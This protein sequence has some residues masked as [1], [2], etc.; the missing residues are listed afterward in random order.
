MTPVEGSEIDPDK[1]P[2]GSYAID[3][4][5]LGHDVSSSL[6]DTLLQRVPSAQINDVTGNPFQPDVQY[7]GFTASPV[8][9]TPQG[10]AVYQNG[11]RTNEAF[12]D[13]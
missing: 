5:A 10:L 7:R 11:V 12:G 8:L 3:R 1:I 6:P 4:A 13:T 2:A 9:G